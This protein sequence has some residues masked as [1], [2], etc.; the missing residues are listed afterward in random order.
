MNTLEGPSLCMRLIMR[1][2][3]IYGSGV[4]IATVSDILG[5]L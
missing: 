4:G 2:K 1:N 5:L 3:N